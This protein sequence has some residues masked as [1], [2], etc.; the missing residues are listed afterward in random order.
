MFLKLLFHFLN[1]CLQETQWL[2]VVSFA[3]KIYYFNLLFKL[4]WSDYNSKSV[5]KRIICHKHNF[6]RAD[7]AKNN[8]HFANSTRASP[9]LWAVFFIKNIFNYLRAIGKIDNVF[10][11]Y[12]CFWIVMYS[13][14]LI[15]YSYS[16]VVID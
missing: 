8:V 12:F 4:V 16:S 6:K 11:R 1:I 15:Y 7:V 10:Y 3:H 5:I 13:F 9:T 14:R 2:E